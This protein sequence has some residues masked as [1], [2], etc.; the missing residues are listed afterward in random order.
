[1]ARVTGRIKR[2]LVPMGRPRYGFLTTDSN[3]VDIYFSER[4]IGND[5][6]SQLSVGTP[7]EADVIAAG[8]GRRQALAIRKT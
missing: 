6:F 7:V 8:D 5:L 3:E 4:Q 2:L 1:M